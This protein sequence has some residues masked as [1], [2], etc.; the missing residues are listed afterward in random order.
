MKITSSD[1]L[2]RSYEADI[3][4]QKFD[5]QREIEK[6]M[7]AKFLMTLDLADT[8]GGVKVSQYIRPR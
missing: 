1:I 7:S 3:E 8:F 6:G 5:C 4:E 2:K